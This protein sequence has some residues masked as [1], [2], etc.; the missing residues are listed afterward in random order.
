MDFVFQRSY[1]GPLKAAIFDWAGTTVDFGCFA[2]AVV[3][4]EVFKKYGI[5]ITMDQA[6]G[7]MGAAKR[8]HI[9][10]ISEMPSVAAAWQDKHGA[11]CSEADIDAMYADFIPMQLKCILDYNELVPGT[12]DCMKDLRARSMKIGGTTGYNGDMMRAVAEDAERRGYIPDASTCADDV[13]AGRPHPWMCI[14]IAMDLQVYPMEAIV[15]VGDTVPD[16]DEGVNAGMWTVGLTVSG[17][18]IGM[19]P[20]EIKAASAET[21][22]AKIDKATKK[23]AQAGAHYVIDSIADLAPVIDDINARLKRG[24]RP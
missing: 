20:E 3:F 24:E 8:D 15:K 9:K 6:R 21:M 5:D 16:I 4:T 18:E 17:N 22:K 11:A 1:R 14:K 13:P 7:P 12:I 10:Q 23:L 2:P 19:T